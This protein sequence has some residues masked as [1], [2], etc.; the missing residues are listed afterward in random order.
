MNS[1]PLALP[2]TSAVADPADPEFVP[3]PA[4]LLAQV[5]SDQTVASYGQVPDAPTSDTST[6]RSQVWQT[7]GRGTK[8]ISVAGGAG[9]AVAWA[10]GT[11]TFT[12]LTIVAV[13]VVAIAALLLGYTLR[14]A[15]RVWSLRRA[16]RA[17]SPAGEQAR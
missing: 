8:T 4:D 16:L 2:A 13:S 14:L 5:I 1:D 10:T 9:A 7:L 12:G 15:A 3:R 6:P 11:S 17:P